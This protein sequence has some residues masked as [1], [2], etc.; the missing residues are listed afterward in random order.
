MKNVGDYIVYQKD[1]C[2]IVKIM[3]NPFSHVLCYSLVPL[4]DESL[5]LSVPV[6]NQS[7]RELMSK[8]DVENLILKIRDIPVIT[9]TEGQIENEYKRILSNGTPE[10]LVAIIKTTYERNQRR[11]DRNKKT[12]DKDS[13]YLELAEN[14]LYYEIA[15]VLEKTF[16]DAK[17]YVL[18]RVD[19]M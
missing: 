7:I 12:S 4:R 14:Y 19:S 5:K 9:I 18:E 1:V 10:D 8:E 15:T 11:I 17:K 13:R 3:E 16:D 2:K 6:T